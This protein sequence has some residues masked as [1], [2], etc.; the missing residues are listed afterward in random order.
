[1]QGEYIEASRLITKM[2][3]SRDVSSNAIERRPS[4][5]DRIGFLILCILFTLVPVHF[6]VQDYLTYY[7]EFI[8]AVFFCLFL[9]KAAKCRLSSPLFVRKALFFF[10]LFLMLLLIAAVFDPGVNLYQLDILIASKHLSAVNPT[11]YVLRNAFLYVPMVYYFAL[12]GL[13]RREINIIA[14]VI[15]FMAPLSVLSFLA[16]KDK[17]IF[18]IVELGGANLEYNSYVPYLTFPFTAAIYLILTVKSKAIKSITLVVGVFLLFFILVSS[19]RQSFLFCVI[20]LLSFVF[21]CEK[22]INRI[23]CFSIGAL[24]FAVVIFQGYEMMQDSIPSSL[25]SKYESISAFAETARIEIMRDGLSMLNFYEFFWGAGLSSVITAGPHN[26]FIRWTQKV[27]APIMIIG[28]M[29]FF[30]LLKDSIQTFRK[31][32]FDKIHLFIALSLFFTIY[33]SLF[34]YPR[35]IVYQAP[36]VYFGLAM[37]LGFY[38]NERY[39]KRYQRA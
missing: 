22:N 28:F 2:L 33:H 35:E 7:R 9:V 17:V 14:G 39:N 8:A 27:G 24:V 23:I 29:P 12:R 32:S 15:A 26:D 1:M 25:I 3:P 11:V 16:F 4:V 30:L 13:S 20:A 34:A 19:S 5:E 31:K 18:D 10:S 6:V 21:L 37:C 38:R 36:F